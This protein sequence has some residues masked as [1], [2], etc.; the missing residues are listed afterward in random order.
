MK[1]LS[2]L[3]LILFA[4]T[5]FAGEFKGKVSISIGGV[6]E[7]NMV[8]MLEAG[9]E[10]CFLKDGPGYV[11]PPMTF[12]K[13][14]KSWEF[15]DSATKASY[16]PKNK[17]ISVKIKNKA[18]LWPETGNEEESISME[19]NKYSFSMSGTM[20]YDIEPE[21][22]KGAQVAVSD[23][24]GESY[25]LFGESWKMSAKGANLVLNGNETER[26]LTGK[27]TKKSRKAKFTVKVSGHWMMPCTVGPIN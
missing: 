12:T 17:K 11:I 19:P 24:S 23:L 1:N 2:I 5:L 3:F 15:K 14:K 16:K 4:S 21:L 9:S 6:C 18:T 22:E 26:K 8:S 10:L 27:I 7:E 20:P 25:L 13:S